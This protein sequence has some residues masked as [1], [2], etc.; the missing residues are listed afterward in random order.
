MALKRLGRMLFFLFGKT[1]L[2]GVIAFLFL[3]F[4]LD[5]HAGPD[6]QDRDVG[7]LAAF[8]EESGLPYFF[9]N[10]GFYAVAHLPYPYNLISTSTPAGRSSFIKASMVRWFG[11]TIS[12]SR[13]WVRISNCSRDFLSTCGLRRTV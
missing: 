13:L 2:E 9:A 10:Q 3:G 8:L 4:L 11:F 7:G 1:Q 12:T 5:N 6:F